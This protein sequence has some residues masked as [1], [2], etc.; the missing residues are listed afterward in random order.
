MKIQIISRRR[1]PEFRLLTTYSTRSMIR[2]M[3]R[4]FRVFKSLASVSLCFART[5][6]IIRLNYRAQELARLIAWAKRK[7]L[8]GVLAYYCWLKKN[9]L[10][11]LLIYRKYTPLSYEI[12]CFLHA[13]AT[14]VFAPPKFFAKGSGSKYRLRI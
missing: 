7:R 4:N 1:S 10:T 8:N 6:L 9:S 11:Q 3:K 2:Y 14:Q 13:L 12:G 5:I